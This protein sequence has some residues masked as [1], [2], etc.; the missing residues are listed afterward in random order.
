MTLLYR[1]IVICAIIICTCLIAFLLM[2]VVKIELSVQCV[3]ASV[4]VSGQ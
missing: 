4:C 1:V 3:R 2:T